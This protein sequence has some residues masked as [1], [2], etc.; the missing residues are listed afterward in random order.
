MN[1]NKIKYITIKQAIMWGYYKLKTSNIANSKNEAILLIAY[2][3]NSS[4]L[5]IITKI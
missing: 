1:I 5:N 4:Y 3:I 2:T